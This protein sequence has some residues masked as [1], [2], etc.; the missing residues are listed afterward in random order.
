MRADAQLQFVDCCGRSSNKAAASGGLNEP[1]RGNSGTDCDGRA[2][3]IGSFPSEWMWIGTS[4][5]VRCISWNR[6][7][8]IIPRGELY[9]DA[10]GRGRLRDGLLPIFL[11][12]LKY[13]PRSSLPPEPSAV[14]G[15]RRLA[16]GQNRRVILL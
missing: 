1:R 10:G 13:N 7:P 16:D 9:Q 12:G 8:C 11:A 4:I 3:D 6:R 2:P 5:P 15:S 14:R